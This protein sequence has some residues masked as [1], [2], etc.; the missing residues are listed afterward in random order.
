MTKKE[1]EILLSRVEGIKSLLESNSLEQF[2]QEVLKVEN[3][4]KRFGSLAELLSHL[5]KLENMAYAAKDF[6]SIDEVA[7]YLNISKSSVYKITSSKELTV[8]KP[9]GK[10]I[11][12][13]RSDLN[14]WIKRNPCLSNDELEKQANIVA[15][16]L[17]RSNKQKRNNKNNKL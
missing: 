4:L 15:Y 13:L 14:G 12:I 9:N 1:L 7:T 10:N 16:N 3:Y 6:L 8:Y 11:F 17:E 2:Q 5:E